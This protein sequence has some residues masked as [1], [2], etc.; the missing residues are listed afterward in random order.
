MPV[1]VYILAGTMTRRAAIAGLAAMTVARARPA[2]PPKAFVFDTFGTVVD[3]RG[4]I[5]AEGAEWG[6]QKGISIDW[7]R[8]AD[9]WRNGYAP[10]MDKV[11]KGEIPW[12]KLDALHR[13]L[14][15]DLLKEFR[16]AG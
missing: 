7:G 12:T 4:S 3:W 6:K 2:T 16:I 1:G 5:I 11:R 13:V 10:A 15:D 8:F 14:L 9:R